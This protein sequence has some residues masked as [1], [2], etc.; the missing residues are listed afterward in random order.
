MVS[1][2]NAAFDS[3]HIFLTKRS[4]MIDAVINELENF[5]M[6]ISDDGRD[7]FGAFKT[8]AHDDLLCAL[9]IAAWY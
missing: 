4:K 7:H 2:L 1:I 6:R 8:G 9:G 3:N 5:E